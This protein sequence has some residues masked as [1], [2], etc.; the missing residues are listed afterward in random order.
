MPA[1]DIKTDA[2]DI[3]IDRKTGWGNPF[4][5]GRDGDRD[6]VCEK[7]RAWLWDEIRAGRITLKELA[8]LKGRRLGCHCAPQRCHGDTLSAAADWAAKEIAVE[9]EET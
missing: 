1:V 9:C 3:R 6:A 4:V 7:Y 2:F 5:M 8:A